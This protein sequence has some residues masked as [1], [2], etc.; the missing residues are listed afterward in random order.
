MRKGV[1]LQARPPPPPKKKRGAAATVP[2]SSPFDRGLFLSFK[3]NPSDFGRVRLGSGTI[4][5]YMPA[6]VDAK[7]MVSYAFSVTSEKK[8]LKVDPSAKPFQ[9]LRLTDNWDRRGC[10][11]HHLEEPGSPWMELGLETGEM[12]ATYSP[13][14][15]QLRIQGKYIKTYDENKETAEVSLMTCPSTEM[16]SQPLSN[17]VMCCIQC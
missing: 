10:L 1:Q 9:N 12:D 17:L 13:V 15:M 14:K 7:G 2:V 16:V 11:L 3:N 4:F 6:Q 5:D 8:W